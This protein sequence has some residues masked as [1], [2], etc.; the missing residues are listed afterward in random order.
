MNCRTAEKWLLR[1]HDRRL[2]PDQ[3]QGLDAH[4]RACPACSARENGYRNL[5][6]VLGREAAPRPRPMFWERLEARMAE[7]EQENGWSPVRMFCRRAV[8]AAL[9]VLSLALAAVLLLS[10]R[11]E[12]EFSS[13][14]SL[15]LRNDNPLSETR[16]LI[17]SNK[18][19]DKN[20]MLIF[21]SA[22]DYLP[23]QGRLR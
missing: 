6:A 23:P 5:F 11:G 13:S 14:E 19:E 17:E 9:A 18:V 22:E 7:K 15:L 8:P 12:R 10:P 3:E 16:T 2:S 1:R 21:A 20:M 4:L